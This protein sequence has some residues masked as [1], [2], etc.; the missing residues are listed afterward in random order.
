MGSIPILIFQR[1]ELKARGRPV[2][3]SGRHQ[4]RVDKEGSGREQ[5]TVVGAA[6]SLVEVRLLLDHRERVTSVDV[7]TRRLA[8]PCHEGEPAVYSAHVQVHGAR[9]RYR[10]ADHLRLYAVL[11]AQVD[12]LR[13]VVVEDG[14]LGT[15]RTDP[16]EDHEGGQALECLHYST[17]LAQPLVDPLQLRRALVPL[18]VGGDYLSEF[19]GGQ[20]L[21]LLQSN[22]SALAVPVVDVEERPQVVFGSQLFG[23]RIQ[24]GSVG[25]LA[26]GSA[27]GNPF[28]IYL[29]P[30]CS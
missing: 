29:E 15:D 10:R 19:L 18:G 1:K 26:V 23:D 28:G 2:L 8:V 14:Q 30:Y 24:K 17:R 22:P 12:A 21:R 7:L 3:R 4:Y 20:L 13:A 6:G 11:C 27:H 5:A 9:L 25:G 16:A